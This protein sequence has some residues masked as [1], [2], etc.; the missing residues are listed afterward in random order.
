METFCA[1]RSIGS[2]AETWAGLER[3]EVPSKTSNKKTIVFLMVIIESGRPIRNGKIFELKL[4][5]PRPPIL[6]AGMDFDVGEGEVE[7]FEQ[8]EMA[9]VK[10]VAV[11]VVA[12][13]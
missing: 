6:L 11:D 13:E 9:E 7:P 3:N 2:G 10:V 12:A 5:R 1:S 8:P 4:I